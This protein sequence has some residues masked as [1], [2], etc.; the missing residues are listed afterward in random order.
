MTEGSLVI[1]VELTLEVLLKAV[2]ENFDADDAMVL[3]IAMARLFPTKEFAVSV[4]DFYSSVVK[5]HEESQGLT[6][7]K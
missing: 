6:T 7:G 2:A 4:R 1:P 5:I 3:A